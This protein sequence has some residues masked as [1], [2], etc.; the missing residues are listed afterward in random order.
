MSLNY[1]EINGINVSHNNLY[2]TDNNK[3]DTTGRINEK[4][5]LNKY[6]YYVNEIL[7]QEP[8]PEEG[9]DIIF[10]KNN[11][12]Y[13]LKHKI[14]NQYELYDV[15]ISSSVLIKDNGEIYILYDF[16]SNV[17]TWNKLE[18]G[19]SF[20]PSQTLLLTNTTS[21]LQTLG[22]VEI[23]GNINEQD[24]YENPKITLDEN[25]LINSNNVKTKELSVGD[26]TTIMISNNNFKFNTF[27]YGATNMYTYFISTEYIPYY[28]HNKS[29]VMFKINFILDTPNEYILTSFIYND[30]FY[31]VINNNVTLKS[32]IIV[33]N[34]GIET[35]IYRTINFEQSNNNEFIQSIN[36]NNNSD[37][38]MV[39]NN[40]VFLLLF[41][42][43]VPSELIELLNLADLT[44]PISITEH[45]YNIH[46]VGQYLYIL[47]ETKCY[48]YNINENSMIEKSYIDE[49]SSIIF[50]DYS[51]SFFDTDRIYIKFK[52]NNNVY[53]LKDKNDTEINIL[54]LNIPFDNILNHIVKIN[55]IDKYIYVLTEIQVGPPQ[56]PTYLHYFYV[57]QMIITK[58]TVHDTETFTFNIIQKCMIG[59]YSQTTKYVSNIPVIQSHT[60][61]DLI[62]PSEYSYYNCRIV[63]P[64]MEITNNQSYIKNLRINDNN[65]VLASNNVVVTGDLIN[66]K[67]VTK[68]IVIKDFDHIYVKQYEKSGFA[69]CHYYQTTKGIFYYSSEANSSN[70][71]CYVLPNMNHLGINMFQN[72]DAY[73]LSSFIYNDMIYVLLYYNTEP[74]HLV[75]RIYDIEKKGTSYNIILSDE[76][77]IN[78]NDY[79]INQ[80]YYDENIVIDDTLY[81]YNSISNKLFRCDLQE[82]TLSLISITT[83]QLQTTQLPSQ[84]EKN[85]NYSDIKQIL[86]YN[87]LLLIP[88]LYKKVINNVEKP[89]YEL[90]VYNIIS[91]NGYNI[92]LQY[93]N[94]QEESNVDLE[95]FNYCVLDEDYL[96]FN[97]TNKDSIYSR[98]IYYINDFEDLTDIDNPIILTKFE[99]FKDNAYSF[100]IMVGKFF[101]LTTQDIQNTTPPTL[102]SYYI[103]YYDKS[104]NVI[105]STKIAEKKNYTKFG[106]V[107]PPII[108]NNIEILLIDSNDNRNYKIYMGSLFSHMFSGERSIINNNVV[109]SPEFSELH[110]NIYVSN[111]ECRINTEP[112]NKNDITHKK[113]VDNK[114]NEQIDLKKFNYV[115]NDIINIEP[116]P[117]TDNIIF[118]KNNGLYTLKHK[119]DNQYVNYNV[120]ISST[121]LV[122]NN[123]EIYVLYEINNDEQTWNKLET[124]SGFDPTKTLQL[125]N[126]N[127]ALQNVGDVQIGGDINEQEQYE[128]PTITLTKEGLITA[129][130]G[131]YNQS[132]KSN[133]LSVGTIQQ[134]YKPNTS[135]FTTNFYASTNL[136]TYFITSE[137]NIYYV[138]NKSLEVN[139]INILLTNDEY[140]LTA[141]IYNELFYLIINNITDPLNNK[142]I[143][144]NGD[145]ETATYRNI[146]L[147]NTINKQFIKSININNSY[148]IYLIYDDKIY[149]LLFSNGLP[150]ECLELTTYTLDPNETIYNV[151]YLNNCIYILCKTKYYKYNIIDNTIQEINYINNQSTLSEDIT[152]YTMSYSLTDAGKLY[153]KY[154]ESNNIY[155]LDELQ[156]NKII[157]LDMLDDLINDHIVKFTVINHFIFVMTEFQE[158]L[159]YIHN[160]HALQM[161]IS[162]NDNVETIT[163]KQIHYFNLNQYTKN[164]NYESNIPILQSNT[165]YVLLE[166]KYG[167]PPQ[168]QEQL[169]YF[170]CRIISPMME[171]TG[172]VSYI[173]NFRITDENIIMN[174][175]MVVMTGNA[176]NEK[177]VTKS[178][179]VKDDY[180]IYIQDYPKYNENY[181]IYHYYQTTKGIFYLPYQTNSRILL[182]YTIPTFEHLSIELYPENDNSTIIQSLFVYNNMLYVLYHKDNIFKFVVYDIEKEDDIYKIILVDKIN[183]IN[184]TTNPYVI[185]ANYYDENI[186][187]DHYVYIY[188]NSTKYIYKC[189]LRQQELYFE[190]LCNTRLTNNI[191]VHQIS[192]YNNLLVLIYYNETSYNLFI[193]NI[194]NDDDYKILLNYN[195]GNI[196]NNITNFNYCIMD[197]GTLYF[198]IVD[199]NDN[200]TRNIYYLDDLSAPSSQD[201][202][203]LKVSTMFK[204][205]AYLFNIEFGKLFVLTIQDIQQDSQTLDSIYSYYLNYY[206]KSDNVNQRAKL[207]EKRDFALFGL[208]IPIILL[209]NVSM[210]LLDSSNHYDIYV[211]SLFSN[212]FSN[213][214]TV[215]NNDVITADY[216]ELQNNL[217][218][219]NTE[220]RINTEPK[221]IN[222]ITHKRYVDNKINEQIELKKFNYIVNEILNELPQQITDDI[223]FVKSN[224]LYT[225][226]H[227]INDE[228]VIY[229]IPISSSV[230]IKTTEEVYILYE[231]DNNVQTWN[232]LVAGHDLSKTMLL[233]NENVGAQIVGNVEIGGTINEQEQYENPTIILD[234]EG[235]IT[236]ED[237]QVK[238]SLKSNELSIG[239]LQQQYINN[240]TQLNILYYY[241]TNLYTYFIIKTS[242]IYSVY[243]VHNISLQTK[244]ITILSNNEY[245]LTAFI[246]NDLLYLITYNTSTYE[247]KIIAYNGDIEKY[248]NN[249]FT[250]TNTNGN[251]IHSVNIENLNDIYLIYDNKID[252]LL[253]INQ[254]PNKLINL[255]SISLTSGETINNVHYINDYLYILCNEEY[256]KYKISDN[257]IET[258]SYGNGNNKTYSYSVVDMNKI[259]F[260]F[261]N[262]NNIYYLDE[263]ET[264]KLVKIN[265]DD[266]T[267][268][269][270]IVKFTVINGFI[271]IMTEIL[272]NSN[273]IHNC[274]V[275]QIIT[276]GSITFKE[277][278]YFNFNQ[279]NSS[280]SYSSNIPIIQSYSNY[281]LLEPKYIA[282]NYPY[283]RVISPMMEIND[284]VA[285]IKNFR[286]NNDNIILSTNRVVTTGE[287]INEK[288]VTNN[289]IIKNKDVDMTIQEYPKAEN[290]YQIYHYYQTT[291]AI[292]YLP[293]EADNNKLLCYTLPDFHNFNI[294]IYD[295]T[296]QNTIFQSAFVYNNMIYALLYEDSTFKFKIYDIDKDGNNYELILNDTLNIT[297]P[298]TNS[299]VASKNYYDENI[300]INNEVYFYNTSTRN[301]YKCNLK[302]NSL[303][304]EYIKTISSIPT[305]ELP[306]PTIE[307]T[308][309]SNVKQ[310]IYINNM[311][312]F[313]YFNSFNEY[314]IYVD[315]LSTT[316]YEFALLY[317]Y[318]EQNYSVVSFNY[319]ILDQNYLYFNI[320]NTTNEETRK[321]YY[322]DDFTNSV[323]KTLKEIPKFQNEVILFNVQFD[324]IF[325]LTSQD[326]QKGTPC[327]HAYYLNYYDK[328]ENVNKLGKLTEEKSDN[329]EHFGVRVP[330]I[331]LNNVNMVVI[332][333]NDNF[334]IYVGSL[335]IHMISDIKTVFNN[336][337]ITPEFTEL[338]NN[339]FITNDECR[340]NTEPKNMND[341]TTKKYVDNT[342]NEQIELKKFNY[343]VNEILTE[344]PSPPT[345][346]IIF[347]LS[348]DIYTLKH[349]V[350]NVYVNYDIPISST[351]LIKDTNNIYILYEINNNV[352]IWNKLQTLNNSETLYLT[353]QTSLITDGNIECNEDIE[354]NNLI[355]NNNSEIK[356][357]LLLHKNL[358]FQDDVYSLTYQ[359]DRC[360]EIDDIYQFQGDKKIFI[361]DLEVNCLYICADAN[362]KNEPTPVGPS[363]PSES[364][365]PKPRIR[366]YVNDQID[367]STMKTLPLNEENRGIS[368]FDINKYDLELSTATFFKENYIY[369]FKSYIKDENDKYIGIKFIEIKPEHNLI[370]HIKSS[371]HYLICNISNNQ[372]IWKI[373]SIGNITLSNHTTL[374]NG[375]NATSG[376]Y[377]LTRTHDAGELFNTGK[378]A[379]S[380]AH[381]E[382][383][384]TSAEAQKSHAEGEGSSTDNGG[385]SA[386]AEG[387]YSK[388]KAKYSHAEGQSTTTSAQAAHSEGQSTTASGSASHSEGQSTTASGSAS[389]SEGT[390]TT[391]N[392]SASHSEGTNTTANGSAS[393]SE[394]TNTTASGSA[395]HTEGS[396]SKATNNSA[397]AEGFYTTA[398]GKY[399]HASGNCTKAQYKNMTVCGM[400]NIYSDSDPDQSNVLNKLFV[401]GNGTV[402]TN[403]TQKD[404][405]KEAFVVHYTGNIVIPSGSVMINNNIPFYKPLQADNTY[406]IFD[407]YSGGTHGDIIQASGYINGIMSLT[408]ITS[409][410]ISGIV[411]INGTIY[412]NHIGIGSEDIN[413]KS[414]VLKYFNAYNNNNNNNDIINYT[415][416]P[417]S[418]TNINGTFTLIDTIGKT[419]KTGTIKQANSTDG[420]YKLYE[421][422]DTNAQYSSNFILTLNNVMFNISK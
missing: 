15:P 224:D 7:E 168:Y 193:Y 342:I 292:F 214:K 49:T 273:Y 10:V 208:N 22:K 183:I 152:T 340:I 332:D 317:R 120:P 277:I 284:N 237:I 391:A 27:Y 84:P 130:N 227:N 408:T 335:F 336:N 137:N 177:L 78:K 109:I 337:V 97:I 13:T 255:K 136:Y 210:I 114:I 341:I 5:A 384:E 40:K 25:G 115:V 79:V 140:I 196:T 419:S 36:M 110:N 248:N 105:Q 62:E 241:K 161:I 122:K 20:D 68:N 414:I 394:G 353:N 3:L 162:N 377:P 358:T 264:D 311:F 348:N 159:T 73:M 28:I 345:D 357:D 83:L 45:I 41:I 117:P 325:V 344:E 147:P 129:E 121:I 324:K 252:L 339:M 244:N 173:K 359:N 143:T 376:A 118:V 242:N 171:I 279:Y 104:E 16:T 415:I 47:C 269:N 229:N 18:T 333:S 392:G 199:I 323:S 318:N 410:S 135:I 226:Y 116:S 24:I 390:N 261:D 258:I 126:E 251:Y 301:F 81:I 347:I 382:G 74:E 293:Y 234:K 132:L 37:I 163:F 398:V 216:T 307:H 26:I 131:I 373:I 225:L 43:S 215:I 166:P 211:G 200:M 192:Y 315:D 401:V 58:D 23:G 417:I 386:H 368:F 178:I 371:N 316:T 299:Y 282:P 80:Y 61:L 99:Q 107:V 12:I 151:N 204:N 106:L 127:I 274:H 249:S 96:Y 267:I 34:T 383:F 276:N 281:V 172:N 288:L 128:N 191:S 253:F 60:D 263:T 280:T 51:Y 346:E 239:N 32:K 260:K 188:N 90:F 157:K 186:V 155:Y 57:I 265:F 411:N 123:E 354:A 103:N 66:E 360:L 235:I 243:Y 310:I 48:V 309:Y 189:Y 138:H 33:Y 50:T 185:D 1:Q 331:M 56:N 388:A 304:F 71:R 6:N 160:C 320:I 405:E 232:K 89:C 95:Y 230:L 378:S 326:I 361:T 389:H 2:T 221:N 416:T 82:E 150:S 409:S 182:C 272:E 370:A 268:D 257:T 250:F 141:F 101:I 245:I 154:Q 209:N 198:N 313:I 238:N 365:L 55:I 174:S 149:L 298:T 364:V 30:L 271:F 85:N 397:H 385:E 231:I 418:D 113:Y 31:L 86:H 328:I 88:Y 63:L 124:G 355:I 381:A 222:D 228:Y 256:L 413:I 59:Q 170:Y 205:E 8:L 65:I 75:L 395:S 266:E 167:A 184:D 203:T 283:C 201:P 393:H 290:N 330:L 76:L 213:I 369:Q 67:L 4:I 54:K 321:I 156:E 294:D 38:Y 180:D 262:D 379:W 44:N 190:F 350:N 11:D 14:N 35:H 406:F 164:V 46:N 404:T 402:K 254:V 375:G 314:H 169:N 403:E 102:Y 246:Y 98:G 291:K 312:M 202:R 334:N 259:Y 145:I 91:G 29:L 17:Q 400:S 297:N 148:D 278:H 119:V 218:I 367:G 387:Y 352:Q 100:N 275:L 289:I 64:M 303:S 93:Y 52:E 295:I 372:V 212:M 338:Q 399:S 219:T 134:E 421:N 220:C 111:T 308:N 207:T 94:S 329:F 195:N 322:L 133:E 179:V 9:D 319:C 42:N 236:A 285:Y 233:T 108:L 175:N 407:Y 153:I 144:Y 374:K 181:N 19:S 300:V 72:P 217:Y 69:I 305:I 240:T 287:L 270:N 412:F 356:K 176:K 194:L 165:D 327:I 92:Y 87:N 420:Y 247:Y 39:Y 112:K 286:I 343:Y 380:Y 142:I 77:P 296:E 349:L 351:V 139:K 21:S 363:Y 223:I 53:Y 206:D 396:Y 302:N 158:G 366:I 197:Q 70:L 362:T 306:T 146:N 187:I 125:T 422:D